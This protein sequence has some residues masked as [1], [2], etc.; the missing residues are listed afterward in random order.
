TGQS[1]AAVTWTTGARSL[2]HPKLYIVFWQVGNGPA[3]L[4]AGVTSTEDPE[5]RFP[6]LENEARHLGG[7]D[8]FNVTTTYSNAAN[9]IYNDMKVMGTWWDNAPINMR[10]SCA[11]TGPGYITCGCDM[12]DPLSAGICVSNAPAPYTKPARNFPCTCGAG[13]KAA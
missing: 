10:P 5:G 6:V 9:P 4:D 8:Y 1:S 13:E 11:D 7:T 2:A 3:D 12:E